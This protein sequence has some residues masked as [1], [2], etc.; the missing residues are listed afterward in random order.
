MGRL[1]EVGSLLQRDAAQILLNVIAIRSIT[2]H[3]SKIRN[4][5]SLCFFLSQQGREREG[6]EQLN[7]HT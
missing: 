4:S 5:F 1:L 7:L 3:Q 2:R 6:I